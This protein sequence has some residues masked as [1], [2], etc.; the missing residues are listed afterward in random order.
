MPC[1]SWL[2]LMSLW[3]CG[4]CQTLNSSKRSRSNKDC[5]A[6]SPGEISTIPSAESPLIP[7]TPQRQRIPPQRVLF[8]RPDRAHSTVTMGTPMSA[9]WI[10][11][12]ALNNILGKIEALLRHV[13]QGAIH[14]W[15]KGLC[16]AHPRVSVIQIVGIL[17]STNDIPQVH[18]GHPTPRRTQ[19]LE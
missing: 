18:A 9:H 8:P 11:A 15:G 13:P 16:A 10:H 1:K 3:V 6:V 14:V 7:R 17:C 5:F 12:P 19:K 4:H 2:K